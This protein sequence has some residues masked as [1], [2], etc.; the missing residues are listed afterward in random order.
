MK[1]HHLVALGLISLAGIT[2]AHAGSKCGEKGKKENSQAQFVVAMA[3][4]L[5]PIQKGETSERRGCCSHHQGVCGCAGSTTQCCD[6]SLSPSC[7]CD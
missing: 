7:Q 3:K 5:K 2:M 1:L 6:G 4:V